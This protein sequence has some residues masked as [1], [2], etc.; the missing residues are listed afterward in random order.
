MPW[1]SGDA[2]SFTHHANTK[3][4]KRAW[5]EIANKILHETGD[6]A[7]AVRIANHAMHN[8]KSLLLK[9]LK[10]MPHSAEIVDGKISKKEANYH[11]LSIDFMKCKGCMM[12][13]ALKC[14]LVRGPINPEG[15]CEHYISNS[16]SI[17][18]FSFGPPS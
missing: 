8:I 2:H 9:I 7:R 13:D 14:K 17:T 3:K 12:Y 6:E 1:N 10:D 16:Q 18:G 4:K 5:K 15:W 11:E